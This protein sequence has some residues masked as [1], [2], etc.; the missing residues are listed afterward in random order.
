[1]LDLGSFQ[2]CLVTGPAAMGINKRF[3]L[4]NRKHFFFT[5]RATEQ[6]NR[7]LRDTVDSPSLEI[8]E[9]PPDTVLGSWLLRGPA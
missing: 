3:P 9:S 7:L 6:W 2:W 5:M 4:N 1:M 8:F